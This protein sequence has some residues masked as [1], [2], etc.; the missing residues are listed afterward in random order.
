MFDGDPATFTDTQQAA[1]WVSV[2]P[3]D[4]TTLHVEAVRYLPRSGHAGRAEGMRLQGSADGGGSWQDLATFTGAKEGWN[5]LALTSASDTTALRLVS[6]TGNTNIAEVQLVTST[7]DKTALDLY[8]D[9]TA[10]LDQDDW[11]AE[12]WTALVAAR[13]AAVPVADDDAADQA[14]V[15]AAVQNLQEALAG[16]ERR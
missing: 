14:R 6:T 8:L 10:D 12:S 1:G 7:V 4:G 11:T 5:Q 3:P 9:E 2:V 16:L 15:D 13:T